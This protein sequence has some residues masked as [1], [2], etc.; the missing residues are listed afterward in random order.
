LFFLQGARFSRPS[1]IEQR[2][3][4]T[5]KTRL[6][7]GTVTRPK[8]PGLA[9]RIRIA[10]PAK[11]CGAPFAFAVKV[12]GPFAARLVSS[13]LQNSGGRPSPYSWASGF[14]S[15]LGEAVGRGTP[16]IVARPR[17]FRSGDG[18]GEDVANRTMETR[19][20]SAWRKST[21]TAWGKHR[22]ALGMRLA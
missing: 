10:E 3:A 1:K 6:H 11:P 22:M 2:A 14:A 8:R 13:G 4:S 17:A 5:N 15:P 19:K 21:R 9:S 20:N 7:A 18:W 16:K 12:L